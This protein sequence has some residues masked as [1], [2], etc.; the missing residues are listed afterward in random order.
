LK[1]SEYV[2][3]LKHKRIAVIGIGVSNT[4]L[5]E[6]LLAG[7]C[8][9]T[10]CDKSERAKLGESAA[11]LEQ[12][13]AK[14]RLG[15]DYLTGL[16][17]DVIF[18]TPG[19]R[20]D[21]PELTAAVK[22]GAVLTSEM[23]VFFDVCPCRIIAV[24]GSEGKTTTTTIIARLLEA[25]GRTVH[26]GGNIGTPLLTRADKMREN[27]FAVVEL[28]SFQLM[29]MRKS[30]WV[31]V[32]T[33]F[34][35]NHLDVHRDMAEYAEA[36]R[37]IVLYQRPADIAVINLDNA[38]TRGFAE[39]AK[40]EVRFFSRK[41]RLENGVF[42]DGNTIYEAVGGSTEP[43]MD[44]ADI[45]L[46]GLHNVENFMAA[47]AATRGLVSHETCR[48]VAGEFGGVEHRCELV[49][50]LRGVR[51]Y[52]DSIATSQ[53]PTIAG[54]RAF[55]KKVILIAG[56]KDKGVPY[57]EIGPVIVEHVK[58]LVLTGLTA[59]KIKAAILDAPNYQGSPEIIEK[60]DF[61]EAI[62]AAHD[63]AADGDIVFL[64]PASTSFDKFKNFEE[65]GNTYK[66]IVNGLE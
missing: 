44:A 51:Y 63:A 24:T 27:D 64:S 43:I 18:R 66:D 49:R 32:V 33:N 7:G 41:D 25:E 37:N 26:M 19:M 21:L 29:T 1:L 13:G 16:D 30:P 50:T 5:I 9:V 20:P 53:T 56:G 62:L 6:L 36:K 40:G 55:D 22:R 65:R 57:D 11:A 47:F 31:A 28:S 39:T 34:T 23:E 35:P 12:K 17:A 46:P 59:E 45:L 3:N 48:R 14:L 2:S 61:R 15:E 60:L 42:L 58:T 52:N 4:P 8:E 10:A 38:A 54:L